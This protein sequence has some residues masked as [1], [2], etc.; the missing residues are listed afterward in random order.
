MCYPKSLACLSEQKKSR[1]E[2]WLMK[3][4]K[5]LN[6]VAPF[7]ALIIVIAIW[8]ILVRTFGVSEKLF[9]SPSAI[10]LSFK[11]N[12]SNVIFPD[13]LISIK[14]ILIGYLIAVPIAFII[15]AF[16]SQ[17]KLV[18]RAVTPLLVILMITPMST[19]VPVFKLNM[20]VSAS[21]KIL[22]IVL[23]ITPVIALNSLSGFSNPPKKNVTVLQ[24]MGCSKWQIFF[25]C[26]FP[27][28]MPQVFTGLELGCILGTIASMGAD[29][30]VGQGGLGYRISVYASFAA[31]SSAFATII[32]AAVVGVIFFEIVSVIEKKVITWK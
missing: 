30:A 23:Q 6:I 26:V 5:A 24:G 16:C 9:P 29:M 15:A 27:N 3:K 10:G 20:G 1:N 28:A 8:E 22:V 2:V 25:K 21:L 32:A 17:F 14:N 19:L 7:V 11:E 13:M 31:T 18:T 4:S 12:F